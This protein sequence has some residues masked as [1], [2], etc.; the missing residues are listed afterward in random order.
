MVYTHILAPTDFSEA[1]N[2]ALGLA[3]AEA[4]LHQARMTLLYVLNHEPGTEVYYTQGFPDDR[5]GFAVEVGATLPVPQAPEP[6]VLRRDHIEEALTRLRD[7]V[8]GS[9]TGTFNVEVAS[10]D[11]ANEIVRMARDRQVDLIVMSTHGRTG[12]RRALL[13]SVAEKVVRHT[14]CPILIDRPFK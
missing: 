13:G 10:G 7:L 14:P 9:F 11:P 5:R 3:F 8:P 2:H 1:A 4:E 6:R 12:L